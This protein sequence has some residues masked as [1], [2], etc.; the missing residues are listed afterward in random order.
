MKLSESIHICR[1]NNYSYI[2]TQLYL[3]FNIRN[4]PDAKTVTNMGTVKYI[5][6][7]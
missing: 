6:Q 1:Y 7:D 3:K 5:E 2:Y 4:I